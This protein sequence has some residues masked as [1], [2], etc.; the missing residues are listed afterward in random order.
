MTENRGPTICALHIWGY[1]SSGSGCTYSGCYKLHLNKET[2]VL[3]CPTC[4]ETADMDENKSSGKYKYK[5]VQQ[6]QYHTDARRVISSMN[7]LNG[8]GLCNIE[9]YQH[10]RYRDMRNPEKNIV[11]TL[12]KM[13]SGEGV[14]TNKRA[15]APGLVASEKVALKSAGGSG[16]HRMANVTYVSK[17]ASTDSLLS[18]FD[19]MIDT[20]EVVRNS[21][22]LQK[23]DNLADAVRPKLLPIH[24]GVEVFEEFADDASDVFESSLLTKN[25]KLLKLAIIANNAE[26]QYLVYLENLSKAALIIKSKI[27]YIDTRIVDTVGINSTTEVFAKPVADSL[28]CSPSGSADESLFKQ[29]GNHTSES[30]ANS[31]SDL[32]DNSVKL[33]PMLASKPASKT[34]KASK[35]AFMLASKSASKSASESLANSPSRS[36]PGTLDKSASGSLTN[37]P[38]D[39]SDKSA[40]APDTLDKSTS[41]SLANSPSDLYDSHVSKLASN[42]LDKHGEPCTSTFNVQPICTNGLTVD[43]TLESQPKSSFD[44]LDKSTCESNVSSIVKSPN[45]LGKKKSKK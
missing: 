3:L 11:P 9:Q 38:S 36:A 21:L 7:I 35:A 6:C 15:D 37:S 18:D 22:P 25:E 44:S 1:V 14:S 4:I 34:P 10:E 39:L 19:S 20:S 43:V 42:T 23:S 45:G 28:S 30:L 24:D 8:I 2:C 41:G 31:P 29:L 33:Q 27:K 40:A 12:T 17:V 13:L 32:S 5:R 16:S 26:K